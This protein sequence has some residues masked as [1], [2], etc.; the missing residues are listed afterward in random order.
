VVLEY[1]D[2]NG[3]TKSE[4]LKES[5]ADLGK[6]LYENG[7]YRDYEKDPYKAITRLAVIRQ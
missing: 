2:K 4:T 1:R 3:K 6:Y 5:V 7:V